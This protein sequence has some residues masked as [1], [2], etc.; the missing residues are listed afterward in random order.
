TSTE[1]K[2]VSSDSDGVK[3]EE[4]S[5]ETEEE[6][7]NEDPKEVTRNVDVQSTSSVLEY[8]DSDDKIQEM[9]L[10]L[11][12]LGFGT[13]W[14]NPTTYFGSETVE[15]VKEFQAYY[16][17]PVTG[18]G[19]ED[20]VDQI[21]EVLASPFQVGNRSELIQEHKQ[22]VFE[23]G[24]APHWT[25]PT[26]YYG[27][28][29]E[30]VVREFQAANELTVNGILDEVTLEKLEELGSTLATQESSETDLKYGFR[31]EEVVD[32]KEDL[33]A[34]GFGTHW[35]NPTT[36]FGPGTV[37]VVEAFQA[38]Y[39]IPVTSEGDE[40]TLAKVEEV[41]T[42]SYQVGN[43][44]EAIQE[45]KQ[46]IF[47]LGYA[48]HWTDPTSYYGTDTEAVVKEFQSA[49]GLVENGIIDEV[50]L[51][52][53]E[54]IESA[55]LAYGLNRPDVVDFKE[56]L[57][58][59]GFGSHWTNP[60]TYFGPGT[61]E[62]VEAFQ[63]YY[64]IPVT[65]EGDETTLAKI[66]EILS[67]PYQAGNRSDAI[68]EVKER[69]FELGYASHWT[70][71][72]SYYGTDTEAVV[73]EFQSANGLVENGIIDEVTLGKIEEIENAPLAYGLRRPDVVD[74]KEDLM[75][76]G[77]GSHWTNPTTYFG[78]G[79]VEVVEAFQA[80]YDIP[81]TSEGDETTLAKIEEILS[82]EYQV[83]NRSEA[84]Q[85][86]KEDI[87]EL[88]FG[89]HW[90]EPT[91][92]YGTDTENVVRQLQ[93]YYS[94]SVNGIID[95]TTLTKIEEESSNLLR[96]GQRSE[97]IKRIKEDIYELGF[98]T[99]WT[100]PTDYYGTDTE[101][102]VRDFQLFYGLA[103][104]GTINEFTLNKIDE[105]KSSSMRQGESSQAIQE[106]K[107]DLYNLGFGSHWT[108][109]TTYYGNDTE[110]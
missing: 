38:Y 95:E 100:E 45:V 24:Y 21:E 83:G 62:V 52:K 30:A 71:P 106:M 74:F 56:D 50:T 79:T 109:P 105:I 93:A 25:N 27:P 86:I 6:K 28:D 36:Y 5:N 98:G 108:N 103:P 81:V 13:H 85:K 3:D 34:L 2:E 76:L 26:E 8:Q 11:V 69:I 65:S 102:V 7:E 23:L 43:S 73:K 87:F 22:V 75:A 54:E 107:E 14:T 78:P 32:F 1:D 70:D 31:S 101:N 53:I 46:R 19:D 39:G 72:T 64:D 20:T 33:M 59:L 91:D 18:K 47:E 92:Y 16:G 15:V 60:T 88:G 41:L 48:P 110:N 29:T 89:T 51:G 63:A 80:Y 44:S 66:E 99:H 58:A 97:E 10:K 35:T 82:S 90:T 104:S 84:I 9:K 37:E 96:R 17:L 61:V 57:M 94:L 4:M 55:S 40:A 77:F 49:N 12:E 42:N 68:Q 67:S